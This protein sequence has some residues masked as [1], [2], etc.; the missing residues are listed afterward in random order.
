M[1]APFRIRRF[2]LAAALA[3]LVAVP[4]GAGATQVDVPALNGS[5]AGGTGAGRRRRPARPSAA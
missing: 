3:V 2:V 5:F 1:R 4:A